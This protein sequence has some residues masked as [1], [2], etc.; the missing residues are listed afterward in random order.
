MTKR[1]GTQTAVGFIP[2]KP[3]RLDLVD[4]QGQLALERCRENEKAITRL[5]IAFA[6]QCVTFA[7][8]LVAAAVAVFR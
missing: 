8:Q 4:A 5:R 6:I 1:K 2:E 3:T 7:I